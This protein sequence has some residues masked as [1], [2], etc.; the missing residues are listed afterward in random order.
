MQVFS[1]L[2][3]RYAT[4]H[5]LYMHVSK[6]LPAAAAASCAGLA[7]QLKGSSLNPQPT[8]HPNHQIYRQESFTIRWDD[9][10]CT[11]QTAPS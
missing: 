9:L 6:D 7:I 11:D 4:E 10:T 5:Y 3:C 8:N 1:Q 2:T